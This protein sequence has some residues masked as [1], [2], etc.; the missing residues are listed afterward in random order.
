MLGALVLA[1][2]MGAGMAR[3]DIVAIDVTGPMNPAGDYVTPF[4]YTQGSYL[5]GFAFRVNS[6]ISITQLGSYDSN[7]SGQLETFGDTAIGVYDLSTNALLV[8]TTVDASDPATGLFRYVSISPLALNTT[9]TYAVVDIS[10]GNYYTVGVTKS[11]S[12]VNAA[13]DLLSGASWYNST[14]S[15]G[16]DTITSS[17]IQPND[18]SA[19]NIFGTP[20]PETILADFGP[21]FQFTAGGITPPTVPGPTSLQLGTGLGVSAALAAKRRRK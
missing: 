15:P 11:S 20:T 14:G 12:P 21:N 16:F 6:A 7:L 9:D 4:N 1:V 17:L 3:A 10:G 18:F 13:I 19:G 8:S 2:A 5:Q